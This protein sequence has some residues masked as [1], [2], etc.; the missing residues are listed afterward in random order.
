M[1]GQANLEERTQAEKYLW[2]SMVPQNPREQWDPRLVPKT[3][4]L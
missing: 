4:L 3:D 2:E 1:R